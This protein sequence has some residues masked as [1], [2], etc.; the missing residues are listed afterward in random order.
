MQRYRCSRNVSEKS[1]R[2]TVK[3][4]IAPTASPVTQVINI[5]DKLSDN[6]KEYVTDVNDNAGISDSNLSYK[7]TKTGCIENRIR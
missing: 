4:T 7:I 6:P 1:D 3:D 2:V 5:G